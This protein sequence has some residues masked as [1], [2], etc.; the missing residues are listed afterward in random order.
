MARFN[1]KPSTLV[2]LVGVLA[3]ITLILVLPQVDLLDT[4]FQRST[5]PLA[6]RAHSI[7]ASQFSTATTI[8]SFAGS[9]QV[10]SFLR[11][12]KQSARALTGESLQILNHS[13]RC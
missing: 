7:S 1:V 2:V 6:I 8:V 3:V 13:L 4:A 11:T 12:E 5:S 9:T 10:Q